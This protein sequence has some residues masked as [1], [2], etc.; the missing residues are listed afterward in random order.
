VSKQVDFYLLSNQVNNAKLKLASRLANKLQRLDKRTLIVT[1]NAED[2][3]YLDEILWS[4][5]GTSFVAHENLNTSG[6]D[7]EHSCIHV[8]AVEAVTQSNLQLE[9]DVLINLSKNVPAYN[10]HFR[11]IAE[12]V[13]ND[14]ADKKLGRSRY[15]NYKTEGYELITH[16][17]E[18]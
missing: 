13:E 1:E 8:S 9:Y 2:C 5:S 7:V 4:F 6:A 10:H 3:D 17:I 12:I 14:D 18:L 11:R 15:Q 16:Q